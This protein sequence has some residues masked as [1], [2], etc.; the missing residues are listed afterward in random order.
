MRLSVKQQ[1]ERD[2]VVAASLEVVNYRSKLTVCTKSSSHGMTRL[3]NSLSQLTVRRVAYFQAAPKHSA[4][5][6]A[7]I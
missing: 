4:R 1:L 5:N 7:L 2:C 6:R 3:T